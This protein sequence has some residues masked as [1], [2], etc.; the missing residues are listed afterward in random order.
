MSFKDFFIFSSGDQFV[1]QSRT[2]L[3]TLVKGDKRNLSVKSFWNQATGKGR[4]VFFFYFQLWWPF[5]TAEMN[6]VSNF[7]KGP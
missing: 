7:S 1:Q 5:C 2:I 3:A 6:F 4:D